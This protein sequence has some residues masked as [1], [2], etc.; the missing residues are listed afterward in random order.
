MEVETK[1]M[2]LV[3]MH[4]HTMNIYLF[5]SSVY[6]RPYNA[7]SLDLSS[8]HFNKPSDIEGQISIEEKPKKILTDA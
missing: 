8:H 5:I 4:V 2:H 3:Y 6:T 1:D 7:Y